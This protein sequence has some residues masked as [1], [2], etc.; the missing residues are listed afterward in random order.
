MS[1]VA[2]L[3]E[4]L[5]DTRSTRTVQARP[6]DEKRSLA[7]DERGAIMV[8]G[9]FMAVLL[10]GMLYYIVGVGDAIIQRERMQD[11]ADAAAFS[12]AVMHARGMNIIALIN[13]VMAA[14]LAVLVIIR[15]AQ[16]LLTVAVAIL[17]G[18]CFVGS[19][20]GGAGAWACPLI[21]PVETVRG[22]VAS[23]GD[24]VERAI[25]PILRACHTAARAVR[26]V[27]PVAAQVRVLDTV[28][29]PG[30]PYN[31]PALAAFAWPIY[32]PLPVEDG[33]FNDLC[34]HAGRYAG[35]IV[36][37]PLRVLPGRVADLIAGMFEGLARSFAAFF[38]GES[39][40]S[41]PS[42][43]YTTT[44]T[45]PRPESVEE[46]TT[47]HDAA[48]CEAAGR[49][50]AAIEADLSTP[51]F[52]GRRC[53]TPDCEALAVRARSECAPP[54]EFE[55][56]RWEERTFYAVWV[57]ERDGLRRA[58]DVPAPGAPEYHEEEQR[59]CGGRDLAWLDGARWRWPYS[60]E[61]NRDPDEYLCK[62]P[63]PSPAE[64]VMR[65]ADRPI[66]DEQRFPYIAVTRI[67]SC[68]R[69][70]EH[71]EPVGG[72]PLTATP[73]EASSMSPQDV[74]DCAELGEEIFQLRSVVIGNLRLLSG[75][76]RIV[77]MAA[78]GREGD[79]LSWTDFAEQLGRVSFS[80]AEFYATETDREEW[81]WSMNWRARM[82]RVRLPER[83]Y[84]CDSG[85]DASIEAPSPDLGDSC[86][87]GGGSDCGGMSA[88]EEV[89]DTVVIH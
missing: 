29:R 88:I 10:V 64:L 41:R 48:A 68:T 12:S 77:K 51:G 13:M 25:K 76:E 27:M 60:S 22:R 55:K 53:N 86:S 79:A 39:G 54:E 66:G 62:T 81:M 52:G 16:A 83:G 38:C 20:F 32:Q 65:F 50:G 14:V 33:D 44:V 61:W 28:V 85:G 75:S 45:R 42:A 24:A 23:A 36:G 30:S 57:K 9:V 5:F 40:S 49:D 43:H 37:F 7:R 1:A 8:M 17:A 35:E 78:W 19:L 47:S 82:R 2:D 18:I 59:P 63:V 26:I 69:D 3:R 34:A 56:Y 84:S 71:D 11:A 72:D 70:E 6:I 73:S 80:Q 58:P 89:I 31:P 15:V 67:F 4:L 74:V 21:S 46:C 87:S